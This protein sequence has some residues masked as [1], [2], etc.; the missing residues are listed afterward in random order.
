[1]PYFGAI[2]LDEEVYT[3][4][5]FTSYEN[6]DKVRTKTCIEIKYRSEGTVTQVT[7]ISLNIITTG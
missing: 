3:I 2:M 7:L 4:D 1:V 5:T 6:R